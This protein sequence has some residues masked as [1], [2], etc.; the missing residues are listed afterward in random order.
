MARHLGL[1][2]LGLLGGVVRIGHGIYPFVG[3]GLCG[4]MWVGV[5]FIAY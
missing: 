3:A 5:I 4:V 1:G 2:V